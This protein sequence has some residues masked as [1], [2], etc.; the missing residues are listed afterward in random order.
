[1]KRVDLT[2]AL[3]AVLS[4]RDTRDWQQFHFP[5]DL[6]AALSIEAGELQELFLWKGQE[7]GSAIKKD[8]ARLKSIS[9]EIA[10]VAIYLLLFCQ[11]MDIDLP[12]VVERKLR[13]N[14]KRY[15]VRR[16]KGVARK[17]ASGR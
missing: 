8:R 14:A 4:F 2:H 9:S 15:P 3:Q 7:A 17:A 16:H 1:M 6:A 5:K 13:E 12:S 10:D 11:E